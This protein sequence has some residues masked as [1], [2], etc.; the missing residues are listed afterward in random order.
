[1]K[2]WF[3]VGV[4]STIVAMIGQGI[5]GFAGSLIGGIIGLVLGYIFYYKFLS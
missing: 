1:M 2:K 4:V 3:I 5:A